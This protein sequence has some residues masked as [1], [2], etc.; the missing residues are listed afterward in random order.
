MR[1]VDPDLDHPR[2]GP[3]YP[4]IGWVT[5]KPHLLLQDVSSGRAQPSFELMFFCRLTLQLGAFQADKAKA[6]SSSTSSLSRF[7][8]S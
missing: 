4:N 2:Y 1:L 6:P 5:Y 7:P 3:K 8:R